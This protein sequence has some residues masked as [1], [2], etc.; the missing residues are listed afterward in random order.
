[1][2]KIDEDEEE[3]IIETIEDAAEYADVDEET[4]RQWVDNGMLL[5]KEGYYF[6]FQLDLYKAT[7]GNPT[8]EQ[9]N[10]AAE[11]YA[12]VLEAAAG[13]PRQDRDPTDDKDRPLSERDPKKMT[14]E[15]RIEFIREFL[16]QF[17]Q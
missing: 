3:Q 11:I 12:D 7:D 10:Q 14:H 8:V 2:L 16:K 6:K 4:I 1:M 17:Q 15:E 5:T 13:Q 9:R